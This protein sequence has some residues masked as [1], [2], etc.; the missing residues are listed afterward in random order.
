MRNVGSCWLCSCASCLD[1]VSG[2]SLATVMETALAVFPA[3]VFSEANLAAN[4]PPPLPPAPPEI[5]RPLPG[6]LDSTHILKALVRHYGRTAETLLAPCRRRELVRPRQIGM[7]LAARLTREP[8]VQIASR[9]RRKDHTT[10]RHAV[11]K[12]SALAANDI[13]LKRELGHLARKARALSRN[14]AEPAPPALSLRDD[15]A[16]APFLQLLHPRLVNAAI[17]MEL[18]AGDFIA[19]MIAAALQQKAKVS[20]LAPQAFLQ[21]LARTSLDMPAR[22]VPHARFIQQSLYDLANVLPTRGNLQA[23]EAII[24]PVRPV[25]A[26]LGD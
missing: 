13:E 15:L 22:L 6:K 23:P 25:A 16:A 17:A 2:R 12:I 19:D 26:G 8:Y 5:P 7:Y 24:R 18:S 4:S 14:P 11:I 21:V 20:P 9:F 3:V 10:V 1:D